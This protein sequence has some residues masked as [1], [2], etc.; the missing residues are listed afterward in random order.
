MPIRRTRVF[1]ERQY[2]RLIHGLVFRFQI[3]K[4]LVELEFEG[5]NFIFTI[6]ITRKINV[7]TQQV[8]TSSTVTGSF[9][10]AGNIFF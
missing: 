4:I 8:I 10:Q 9:I 1:G 3:V 7:A 2:V 5:S 6:K